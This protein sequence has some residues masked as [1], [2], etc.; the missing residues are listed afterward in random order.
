VLLES[1]EADGF[2]AQLYQARK[3]YRLVCER[4][5]NGNKATEREIISSY[6]IA[7]GLGFNGDFRVGALAADS[8]LM[9]GVRLFVHG[10][11]L[12]ALLRALRRRLPRGAAH[13]HQGH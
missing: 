8:R 11:P 3:H 10:F 4:P 12:W 2:V 13:H 7:Q 5:N 1:G 6:Q 9:V